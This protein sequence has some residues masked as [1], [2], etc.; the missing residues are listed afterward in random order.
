MSLKR[1]VAL[2]TALGY[3]GQGPF[4]A[5]I[6]HRIGGSALFIFLTVYILSLLGVQAMHA[7]MGNWIFQ[8]FLLVFGLFHALNGLRITLMDLKPKWIEHFR[9][10][11]TV[12]W[13]VYALLGGFA[14]FVVLQNA[15]GG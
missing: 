9:M 12:E 4:L 14:I 5:Y 11:M 15:F 3:K 8:I 2:S 10:A 7:L 6:L 13:V 1:N